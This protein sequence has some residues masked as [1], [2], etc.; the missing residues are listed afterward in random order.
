MFWGTLLVPRGEGVPRD[1]G[2]LQ[3]MCRTE[4]PTGS[5]VR[6]GT[7]ELLSLNLAKYKSDSAKARGSPA[8]R[9]GLD[10]AEMGDFEPRHFDITNVPTCC[11]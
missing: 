6:A 5:L 8:G 11:T 2:S 9:A 10:M 4:W 1:C 7:N 3:V